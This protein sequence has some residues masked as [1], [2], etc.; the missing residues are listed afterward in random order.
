MITVLE[1]WNVMLGGDIM[2][3]LMGG[4]GGVMGGRWMGKGVW[5]ARKGWW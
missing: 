1:I 2:E 5:K 3:G 4:V